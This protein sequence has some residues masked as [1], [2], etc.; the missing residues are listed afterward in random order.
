MEKHRLPQN[1]EAFASECAVMQA[2]ATRINSHLIENFMRISPKTQQL[3]G[4]V[5]SYEE[6][7]TESRIGEV[8]GQD[9]VS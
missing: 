2:A 8:Y 3:L 5:S 4:M 9:M 7:S 6:V 1:S